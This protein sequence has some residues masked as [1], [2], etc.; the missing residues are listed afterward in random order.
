[1]AFCS[2]YHNS[3]FGVS[4][5]E[6]N[7]KLHDFFWIAHSQEVKVLRHPGIN[8]IC[9]F[10]VM[11]TAMCTVLM[12]KLS[13]ISVSTIRCISLYC[14]SG[15]RAN[16]IANLDSAC[17]KTPT[18][19]FLEQSGQPV[20][21]DSILRFLLDDTCKWFSIQAPLNCIWKIWIL[22]FFI[23]TLFR[24]SFHAILSLAYLINKL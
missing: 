10:D 19:K 8:E 4:P 24:K 5:D 17:W 14:W 23:V 16:L 21:F 15:Q 12:G 22:S 18:C 9:V 20:A 13:Y 6:L 11:G 1:M 2:I 7:A 3:L